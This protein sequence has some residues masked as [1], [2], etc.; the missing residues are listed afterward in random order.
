MKDLRFITVE[1]VIGAGKT[2]L[3]KI[4]AK[5][6]HAGMILEKFEDNPFLENFYSD[7]V[8]HAFHTQLYFLM[9]RYRQQRQISQID[10]FASRIIA[11]YFFEKDRIFAEINLN[12]EEFALYD[13]I[14]GLIERDVPKPDLVIYLQA[15]VEFLYKRI[16][17]RD[18]NF[19][20]NIDFGYIEQLCEAYNAFFF[21]YKTSPLLIVDIKG[22]DFT[23][24]SKDLDLICD[25]VKN[26]K[27]RRRILSRQW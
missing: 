16:R 2:S 26:L 13:K 9:S 11:D 14:Y 24:N 15:S 8:K 22:F 7:P 12:E 21:H 19:E 25:E 27:E 17:Q 3:V 20:S 1:G 23:G 6:F 4:L 10:L 18:R 5:R